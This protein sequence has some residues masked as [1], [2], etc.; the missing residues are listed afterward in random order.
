M[1]ANTDISISQA[2]FLQSKAKVC[3]FRGGVQSG[4]SYVLAMKAILSAINKESFLLVSFSYPALRDVILRTIKIILNNSFVG[5]PYKINESSM[6][7]TINGTPIMLRSADDPDSIRGIFASKGGIDECR[8]FKSRYVYDVL[9]GRLSQGNAPQIYMSS[10]SKG[11]NWVTELRTELGDN[12]EQ[13][14]QSSLENPFTSNEYKE[15]LLTAYTSKFARQEI[16]GDELDLGSGV[17]NPNWFKTA[18]YYKPEGYAVRYWDVAVSTKTSADFSSGALLSNNNGRITIHDIK[19]VK[20]AYPDL[21]RLM[22]STA[23][24][25]GPNVVIGIEQAGQQQGF[26]DDLITDN[27]FGRFIIRPHKPSGDKYNR[28]MPW[29]ARAEQGYV[30]VCNGSWNK[31]FHDECEAFTADDSH[32]HDDQIDSVSGSYAM[33]QDCGQLIYCSD[34]IDKDKLNEVVKEDNT[35]FAEAFG[36]GQ[37]KAQVGVPVEQMFANMR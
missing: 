23:I 17:I 26:I 19:R 34:Q 31:L 35:G 11:R 5:M 18:D 24:S 22:L 7:I 27:D 20:L 29:A 14:T 1:I 2:K 32:E 3:Y 9:V 8:N 4:K 30:T 21:R 10:T 15:S 25:D 16:Y 28:A 36:V 37:P 13:I 33:Q 6:T 12:F